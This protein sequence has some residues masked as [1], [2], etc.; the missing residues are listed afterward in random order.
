MNDISPPSVV[1]RW[2]RY[3]LVALGI[4]NLFAGLWALASPQG[5]YDDF[6]GFA[7]RLVSAEP[8]YNAHLATD[9][10][11]GL[12]ASALL[13]LVAAVIAERNV[14]RLALVGYA[15]FAVP[16]AAYHVFNPA[17]GLTGAEDVQNAATL[18]FAAIVSVGLFFYVGRAPDRAVSE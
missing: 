4:P 11:A 3:A 9:A 18:A 6:P 16:H 12:F 13:L 17:P 8:P 14:V 15:A 1:P 2:V 10:G 5:W 7:P